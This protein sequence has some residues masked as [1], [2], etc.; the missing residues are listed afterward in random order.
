MDKQTENKFGE[1]YMIRPILSLRKKRI[2]IDVDTQQD[3]FL[4]DGKMCVRNHR[5]VLANIRR[6]MA[7]ARREHIRVVSTAL[8]HHPDDHHDPYCLIGTE[9]VKKL[10]YTLRHRHV[11][12]DADDNTDLPRE[13]V[14]DSEQIVLY[15]RTVDPFDEPRAER[16]LTETKANEFIV[17]GGPTETAVLATVLGLL[18]RQK[19]VVLVYD[20]VGSLD[21]GA[22]EVALRKMQAKG[23]KLV[24]TRSL[25]GGS[26]LRVVGACTCD[27]CRGRVS[28]VSSAQV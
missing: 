6:V 27:R 23:A 22:A 4:A 17:I 10:R 14:H 26:S 15:K 13:E 25:F 24:D 7:W 20:A 2:L 18:I 11:I 28:K 12:F 3:F 16:M 1:W 9:G 8:V 19:N 5:R 21:K